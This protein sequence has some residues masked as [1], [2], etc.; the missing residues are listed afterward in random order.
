[1]A[2]MDF[3]CYSV[4]IT[5]AVRNGVSNLRPINDGR[6]ILYTWLRNLSWNPKR[7]DCPGADKTSDKTAESV[8]RT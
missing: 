5:Y 6:R 3:G 8:I 4:P 2:K 1:M 7:N